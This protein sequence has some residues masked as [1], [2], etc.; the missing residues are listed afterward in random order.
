MKRIQK[1][2]GEGRDVNRRIG[3]LEINS[4]VQRDQ[5]K[6]GV[7]IEY[8]IPQAYVIHPVISPFQYKWLKKK[9]N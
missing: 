7:E 6:C 3:G 1:D 9:L 2:R 4:L 8:I 5:L